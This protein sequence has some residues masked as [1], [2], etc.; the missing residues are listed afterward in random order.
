MRC[1]VAPG[2]LVQMVDF[3]LVLYQFLVPVLLIAN[4]FFAI[5]IIFV[6]RKKPTRAVSWLLVLFLLPF[7]GFLLFLI[8]GQ[9]YRKEKLFSLKHETDRKLTDLMSS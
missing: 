3:L 6:E 2:F 7:L 4:I 5:T 8:F 1:A 9:N